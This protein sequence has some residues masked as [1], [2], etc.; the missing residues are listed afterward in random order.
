MFV[1][2]T[3]KEQLSKAVGM[4]EVIGTQDLALSN[5]GGL[6]VGAVD[7]LCVFHV[8]VFKCFQNTIKQEL[9]STTHKGSGFLPGPRCWST[10]GSQV[11]EDFVDD[12][13]HHYHCGV[14]KAH[15]WYPEH[16]NHFFHRDLLCRAMKGSLF[17][18]NEACSGDPVENST[19]DTTGSHVP[20]DRCLTPQSPPTP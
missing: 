20:R 13:W 2:Y 15:S 8:W 7:G 3:C 11:C 9:V 14:F 10:P 18:L 4:D 6:G 1:F 5:L 16:Q 17:W 19:R 12:P